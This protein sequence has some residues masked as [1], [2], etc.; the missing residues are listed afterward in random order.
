MARMNDQT[1]RAMGTAMSA[2]M[3]LMVSAGL[4]VGASR[5]AYAGDAP[6][7]V[8]IADA[9][10]TPE[11][12]GGSTQANMP[13]AHLDARIAKLHKQLRITADQEPQFKAFTDAMRG[14]AQ[15]MH[16]LFQERGK[17]D[18]HTAVG[19]LRWYAKLTA[20]HAEAL[21]KLVPVFEALYQSLSDKQKE[22]AN[23]VF[24]EFGVRRP[25][26]RRG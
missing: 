8:L 13:M 12:A 24:D 14:N 7:G 5:A 23:K 9:T 15:T 11:A 19:H 25:S 21:N 16:V 26:H 3:V 18:D 10:P 6:A 17:S 20:A 4:V 22:T 2:L 1:R